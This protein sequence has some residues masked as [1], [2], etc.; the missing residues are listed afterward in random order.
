MHTKHSNTA[1]YRCVLMCIYI[2]IVIIALYR[3]KLTTI[4]YLYNKGQTR[5]H[6]Q[7]LWP[8]TEMI[9]GWES[10]KLRVIRRNLEVVGIPN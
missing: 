1:V 5:T 4:Q 9:Q 2:Y 10:P 8:Q 6:L 3:Q 7:H